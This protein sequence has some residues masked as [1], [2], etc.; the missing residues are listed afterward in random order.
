MN[1]LKGI[2]KDIGYFSLKKK[3]IKKNILLSFGYNIKISVSAR[4][5]IYIYRVEEAA[6]LLRKQRIGQNISNPYLKKLTK[7]PQLFGRRIFFSFHDFYPFLYF[8]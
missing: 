6:L 7:M 4:R 8:V 5:G 1:I 3:Y 2:K